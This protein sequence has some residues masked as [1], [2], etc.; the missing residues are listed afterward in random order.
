MHTIGRERVATAL[1]SEEEAAHEAEHA[2]HSPTSQKYLMQRDGRHDWCATGRLA[3]SQF[4]SGT[5]QPLERMRHEMLRDCVPVCTSLCGQT[6]EREHAPHSET[7][8]SYR[9]HSG[10]QHALRFGGALAQPQ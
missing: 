4:E 7:F 2:P 3:A 9:T 10:A 1:P 8:Q 6:H 5:T